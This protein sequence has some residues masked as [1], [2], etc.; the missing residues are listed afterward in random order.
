MACISSSRSWDF[1]S[2]FF[3]N[4]NKIDPNNKKIK[5]LLIVEE[6]NYLIKS[7]FST[8]YP[9]QG[10]GISILY[11]FFL[12][13]SA[14]SL[15]FIFSTLLVNKKNIINQIIYFKALSLGKHKF[16]WLHCI[17]VLINLGENNCRQKHIYP[18]AAFGEK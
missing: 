8:L 14:S 9:N 11:D 13:A 18:K 12:D 6:N 7:V 2:I 17:M 1:K 5:L 4:N 10:I 16:I 15:Y 3:N